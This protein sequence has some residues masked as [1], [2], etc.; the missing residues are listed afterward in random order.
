MHIG[1]LAALTALA[2]VIAGQVARAEKT[3][4]PTSTIRF[5]ISYESLLTR[6]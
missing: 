6:C 4:K 2:W 5:T 3:S 1:A